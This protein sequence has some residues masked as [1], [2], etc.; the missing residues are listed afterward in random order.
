MKQR[1]TKTCD[2]CG[3]LYFG[4]SSRMD[5]LC[6]EC[7]HLIYGYPPCAHAFADGRCR[8]CHWDGSVSPYCE[9]LKKASEAT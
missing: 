7:T 3:S 5:A 6:P 2:E 1:P 4:D 8:K 9:S